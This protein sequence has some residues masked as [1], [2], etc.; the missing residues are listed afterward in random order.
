[1]TISEAALLRNTSS[2]CKST[3][4]DDPD[5]LFRETLA[6]AERLREDRIARTRE[7][8]L[9]NANREYRARFAEL[10]EA[11][12]ILDAN[13]GQP[14]FFGIYTPEKTGIVIEHWNAKRDGI[15]FRLAIVSSA[16]LAVVFE[17]DIGE[18]TARALC[19]AA[20]D[21]RHH[22]RFGQQVDWI[23]L[24]ATRVRVA[25]RLPETTEQQP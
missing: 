12:K 9:S 11:A 25:R 3:S 7:W 2:R 13:H 24:S 21:R 6:L 23:N 22:D 15:L 17:T 5:R 20:M 10:D 18:A 8:F 4:T 19:R 16:P 14:C 1:M